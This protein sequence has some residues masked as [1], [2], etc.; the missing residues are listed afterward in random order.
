[1]KRDKAV[2]QRHRGPN[3]LH[4]LFILLQLRRELKHTHTNEQM[5]GIFKTFSPKLNPMH[6]MGMSGDSMEGK[7]CML[8]AYPIP[9][10][11]LGLS[12]ESSCVAETTHTASVPSSA[13]NLLSYSRAHAHCMLF[14]VCIAADAIGYCAE[15][16]LTGQYSSEK[17]PLT[18]ELEAKGLTKEDWEA[19]CKSLASGKGMMGM[20]GGFSKAISKANEDYLDKIGCIGVYA[21]YGKGQKCMVVLTKE[22]ATPE[23]VTM[24]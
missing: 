2:L 19:I 8:S 18:P 17:F 11:A 3:R 12:H 20:D 4:A 1:M 22:A 10:F 9:E 13:V 23:R 5:A 15:G 6:L 14:L 24:P 16:S 21:E 7:P